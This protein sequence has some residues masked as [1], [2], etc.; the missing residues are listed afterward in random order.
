MRN[1]KRWMSSSV[2]LAVAVA[3]TPVLTPAALAYDAFC[4]ADC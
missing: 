1:F 3:F 2:V 4:G